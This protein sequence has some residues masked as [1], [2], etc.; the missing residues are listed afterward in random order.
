[1]ARTPYSIL[2][3]ITHQ[4]PTMALLPSDTK[5]RDKALFA[6]RLGAA[7]WKINKLH[8]A[9]A[10]D[11]IVEEHIGIKQCLQ[12]FSCRGHILHSSGDS[13]VIPSVDGVLFQCLT[14]GGHHFAGHSL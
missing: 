1:M 11:H 7:S 9:Y 14:V 4:C 6:N 10:V 2:G 5:R 12:H 8:N 3:M 13:G